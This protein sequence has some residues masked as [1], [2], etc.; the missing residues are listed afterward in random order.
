VHGLASLWSQGAFTGPVPG[1]RL[2]DALTVS[3]R[4]AVAGEQGESA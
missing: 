1:A 3:L 4:L 2:E